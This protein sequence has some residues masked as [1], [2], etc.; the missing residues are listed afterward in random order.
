MKAGSQRATKLKRR[1]QEQEEREPW[2]S[3]LGGAV[4]P[5]EEGVVGEAREA[6]AA[7][8]GVGHDAAP[9]CK[10]KMTCFR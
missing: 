2:D 7:A 3:L 10:K 5:E 8:A 6:A 4:E 1:K 9:A